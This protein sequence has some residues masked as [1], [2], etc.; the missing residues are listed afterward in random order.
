VA[1][2]RTWTSG[3]RRGLTALWL[4]LLPAG[5]RERCHDRLDDE[6]PTRAASWALAI[7]QL[8]LIPVWAL[9]AIAYTHHV[10]GV[11]SETILGSEQQVLFVEAMLG[12]IAL[13]PLAYLFSLQG[14]VL[15]YLIVTGVVR[16]AGLVAS[17]RPTGDPLVSVLAWAHRHTV[18]AFLRRRRLGQLGPERPDRIL[19]LDGGRLV[20][21][22]AREKPDWNASVTIQYGSGYYRLQRTE[23]RARGRWVDIAYVLRPR[24]AGELI[25]AVA[26]LEETPSDTGESRA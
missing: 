20:V 2:E 16:V 9:E 3:V 6:V 10:A 14:L 26:R 13:G 21:L 8:C 5:E 25:R 22:S 15:E 19:R 24:E 1:S 11:Q 23:D 17:D 12:S 18:A 4:A 7:V